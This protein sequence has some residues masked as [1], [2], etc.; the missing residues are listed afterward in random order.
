MYLFIPQIIDLIF[1]HNGGSKNLLD[2]RFV[3]MYVLSCAGLFRIS[4]LLC[5]RCSNDI[6]EDRY[7]IFVE[8]CKADKYREGSWVHIAKTGNFTCPY[9]YFNN[10]LEWLVFLLSPGRAREILKKNQKLLELTHVAFSNHSFRSSGATAAANLNA[11]DRL[12]KVH[13]TGMEV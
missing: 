4:K 3:C 13:A 9:T 11:P 12:F 8:V 1:K 6:T 2:V 10:Y 7:K 5:I